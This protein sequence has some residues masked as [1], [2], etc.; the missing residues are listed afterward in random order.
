MNLRKI[1][2]CATGIATGIAIAS[3]NEKLKI[4]LMIVIVLSVA[5]FL[6]F[7]QN[8]RACAIILCVCVAVGFASFSLNM[9]FYHKADANQKQVQ[10]VGTVT[11]EEYLLRDCIVDGKRVKGYINIK[12]ARFKN[13]D[14]I[15]LTPGTV[16]GFECI[17][18]DYF[19]DKDGMYVV[20]YKD[21]YRY[22]TNDIL[23]EV[24]VL[25]RKFPS[26]DEFV[27]LNAKDVLSHYLDKQS[28]GVSYAMLFGNTDYIDKDTLQAFR[29]VGIAHV[30]AVSGLHVG[31][32]V[33]LV[34]AFVKKRKKLSL[35]ITMAVVL[36]YAWICNFS[37]SIIR[38]MLMTGLLLLAKAL[39]REPDFLSS[40]STAVCVI[41]L[42]KPFYLFDV[43]FQMS[44]GAVLGIDFVTNTLKRVVK[45]DNKFL[46]KLLPALG[47][48]I[49]ATLGTLPFMLQY[50]SQVSLI[51][52]LANVVIIPVVSLIFMATLICLILPVLF[53]TFPAIGKA[54]SVVIE[55]TLLFQYV[56][57]L[58]L[59]SFN[60]GIIA[61]FIILYLLSGH[62]RYK[63]WHRGVY[64][65]LMAVLVCLMTILPN[66][67]AKDTKIS[68][69]QSSGDTFC[70]R[71]KGENYIFSKLVDFV[72]YAY[73]LQNCGDKTTLFVTDFADFNASL[74]VSLSRLTQLEIKVLSHVD[75]FDDDYV[76]LN[77][78][79][80][81]T[82]RIK[83]FK[84]DNINIYS[85][86]YLGK[87]LANV[88][89]FE[90][91]SFAYVNELT[92]FQQG[93]LLDNMPKCD[94]Y[95]SVDS[96]NQIKQKHPD[97]IVTTKNYVDN[98]DIY[99][100]YCCGNFTISPRG[101]KMVFA[102]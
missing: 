20:E 91:F 80:I 71:V 68:F 10:V 19:V 52:V 50:F 41:L 95:Y 101:A 28:F 35:A 70:V 61:Y 21:G 74:A 24:D 18:Q 4:I 34:N 100:T 3:M 13:E 53:W 40:L 88:I 76:L 33:M 37:P 96:Y 14:R 47:I 97:S 62:C 51:G 57:T 8:K 85:F 98:K 55:S 46:Q 73:V 45:S 65:C 42:V 92:P 43:G 66:I 72:D 23:T 36:F 83:T 99:S 25:E 67:P 22:Y 90:D 7:V 32:V 9:H 56:P 64:A 58:T 94:A 60:L 29:D 12:G 79:K 16:V 26:L 5:T 59:P 86:A 102:K 27:R 11:D 84:D 39:G 81:D 69:Y 2:L 54:I 49:G 6:F 15:N 1:F 87:V 48:S 31:F 93:Y 17:L 38:A 63:L 44:V 89:E 82:K 75:Y 77:K 78:N 30:F